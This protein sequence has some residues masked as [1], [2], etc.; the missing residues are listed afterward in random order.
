MSCNIS[1]VKTERLAIAGA[2][3]IERT[4]NSRDTRRRE[5]RKEEKGRRNGKGDTICGLSQFPG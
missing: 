2:Y 4:T 5:G 1:G 3:L